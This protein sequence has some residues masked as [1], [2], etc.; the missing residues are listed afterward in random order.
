MYRAIDANINRAG[1]GAR[2]VEDLARF[3]LNNYRLSSSWKEIRHSI[4]NLAGEIAPDRALLLRKRDTSGD[5]GAQT[6]TPQESERTGCR[7]L[8]SINIRR[9]EEGLRSLEEFSKLIDTRL[10]EK[11]KKLRF[12]VYALEKTTLSRFKLYTSMANIHGLYAII[13]VEYVK[14]RNYKRCASEIIRGG[15][16]TIQLRAKVTR[17]KKFAELALTS[18][19]LTSKAGVTFIVNDRVDIAL[20]SCADGVHL[21][22]DDIQARAARSLIGDDNLIGIS[23]HS[24]EEASLAG[25]AGA[26]YIGLGPIFKTETK[27]DVHPPTG[28]ELIRKVQ[29]KLNLPIIAIGGINKT[30]IKSVL[31]A[32]ADG[33]A[34]IS[35]IL[36]EADYYK[37]A[38]RL[39][40]E[41]K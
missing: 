12:K 23:T 20:L 25:A 26:D 27:Q 14:E 18:R 33:V 10:G 36:A 9:V 38:R 35:G 1:E 5:V 17:T 13:D 30:N 22:Q 41:F 2:V 3:I 29:N 8:A 40:T 39:V 34:V 37:A 7:K 19:K 11:F 21:G 4:S 32:G 6:Y 15:A 28:V 31:R 16:S 24:L